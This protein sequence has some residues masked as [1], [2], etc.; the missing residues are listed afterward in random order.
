[1]TVSSPA[2]YYPDHSRLTA[3]LAARDEQRVTLTFMQLEQAIL[4]GLLPYGPGD[5][6]AG[7]AML[8]RPADIRTVLGYQWADG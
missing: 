5:K 6:R 2:F 1:V 4:R 8:R 7:R 3:Y